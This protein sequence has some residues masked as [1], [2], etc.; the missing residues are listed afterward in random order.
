MLATIIRAA[1]VLE[2]HMERKYAANI[3]PNR[4]LRGRS[5]KDVMNRAIRMWRFQRSIARESRNPAR[6]M[7]IV[8]LK[9]CCDTVD[10]LSTPRNG[11]STTGNRAVMD[12]GM[13]SVTQ[14]VAIRMRTLRVRCTFG[15][16]GTTGMNNT[17][18]A[19][20]TPTIVPMTRG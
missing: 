6:N 14:Q 17:T 5:K 19:K 15:L 11:N 20:I 4:M 2:I 12:S 13:I 16:S 3:T 9:Y 18:I 8:L 1:A 7:K 10:A